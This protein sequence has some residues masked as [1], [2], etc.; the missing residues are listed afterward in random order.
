V[1]TTFFTGPALE[2]HYSCIDR[3]RADN[4]NF[5]YYW[6][7]LEQ[8]FHSNSVQ[9]ET[10]KQLQVIKCGMNLDE[11]HEKFRRLRRRVDAP[12]HILLLWYMSELP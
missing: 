2:W 8:E 11:Y 4:E 6:K 3:I 7:F 1:T 5:E 9:D 12:E 10:S